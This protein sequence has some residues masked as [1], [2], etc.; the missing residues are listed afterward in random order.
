MAMSSRQWH[1]WFSPHTHMPYFIVCQSGRLTS[2]RTMFAL[3]LIG[4]T[5]TMN[6]YDYHWATLWARSQDEK[7]SIEI[8]KMKFQ[9]WLGACRDEPVI[10]HQQQNWTGVVKETDCWLIFQMWRRL[11]EIHWATFLAHQNAHFQTLD[12]LRNFKRQIIIFRWRQRYHHR[13][14]IGMLTARVVHS[15]EPN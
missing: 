4:M 8:P 5:T 13:R 9:F 15:C 2:Q 6:N 14:I 7:F 12:C 1:S 3:S 10:S 11:Q